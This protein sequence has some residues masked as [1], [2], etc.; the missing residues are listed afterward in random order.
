M[1][2]KKYLWSMQLLYLL[3]QVLLHMLQTAD[4]TY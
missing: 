3:L 4:L 2:A 1:K